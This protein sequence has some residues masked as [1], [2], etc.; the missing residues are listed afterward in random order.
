MWQTR[1]KD[2]NIY[3]GNVFYIY[4]FKQRCVN[5]YLN[6]VEVEASVKHKFYNH[7]DTV[8]GK[9]KSLQVYLHEK[10]EEVSDQTNKYSEK[11]NYIRH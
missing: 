2:Q 1:N 6:Y 9:Q 4:W 11:G 3:K 10:I 5:V 7:C 8:F